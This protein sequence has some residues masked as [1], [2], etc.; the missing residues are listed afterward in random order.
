MRKVCVLQ[1]KILHYRKPL[2]NKLSET[3]DLTV[4][5]AGNPTV[6]EHDQY[7]EIIISSKKKGVFI[8]QKKLI[9]FLKNGSYDKIIGMLDIHW[10]SII[11]AFFKFKSKFIW[12]GIGVSNNNLGNKIRALFLRN[13]TPMI[14]YTKEGIEAFKTLGLNTKNFFHCNNTFHIDN[15]IKCYEYSSKNSLLFVGSLD[16]RKQNDI[17]IN[18]FKNILPDINSDISLDIV[19]A[20]NQE[21]FLKKI[22][23]ELQVENRVVFHGAI[24]DTK[25][26]E[27]FYKKAICSVSFGQAGLSVLQSLG[28]GVPFITKENA[29]SGGEKSNIIQGKNGFLIKDDIAELSEHIKMLCLNSSL[30]KELGEF[31]YKYYTTNCTLDNMTNI[32]TQA[33]NCE[34]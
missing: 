27:S 17:L 28:Y 29:I 3:F 2:Y 14:F 4:I 16:K 18:A 20:G 7:K 23:K 5:H 26:L 25:V 19:G 6:N 11:L 13:G 8:F 22:T 15:R 10:I 34:T 24:T 21:Q 9:S 30:S 33:I 31:A 1:N 12:W 32:F